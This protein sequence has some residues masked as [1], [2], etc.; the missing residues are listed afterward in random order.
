MTSIY[1]IILLF[2]KFIAKLHVLSQS[3]DQSL[4]FFGSSPWIFWYHLVFVAM[5]L[6]SEMIISAGSAA[7]I[8]A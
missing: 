1:F 2:L 6:Q 7:Q 4:A 3:Y 5:R 8:V